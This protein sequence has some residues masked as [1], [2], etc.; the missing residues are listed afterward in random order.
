MTVKRSPVAFQI[1][2]DDCPDAVRVL[3][4]PAARAVRELAG[5]VANRGGAQSIVMSGAISTDD[6]LPMSTRARPV[7]LE[8]GTNLWVATNLNRAASEALMSSIVDSAPALDLRV[9]RAGE[10]F[11]P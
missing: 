6:D 9:L 8:D 3:K 1:L 7:R 2:G 10:P 11:L 4:L 5:I